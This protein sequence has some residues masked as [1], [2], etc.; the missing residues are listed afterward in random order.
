MKKVKGLNKKLQKIKREFSWC[1]AHGEYR[2]AL[3][4]AQAAHKLVPSISQPVSDMAV[5]SIYLNDWDGALRYAKSA[6]Q[7][8]P[9][10][11]AALDAASHALGVLKQYE[12]AALYGAKAIALRDAKV[13]FMSIE[14]MGPLLSRVPEGQKVIA[15]SLFGSKPKYCETAYLNVL[16]QP[17]IYPGWVCRFYVDRSVPSEVKKRLLGKGAQVIE[18]SA[19]MMGWPGTVWR[20]LALDDETVDRVIFRDADSIIG[21]RESKAVERWL[22]SD[23]DFH[24]MRDNGSHTELILAGMW[25]AVRGALPSMQSL[26]RQYLSSVNGESRFLDQYF[27]RAKVWPYVRN[28]CLHH[29]DIFAALGSEP[30]PTAFGEADWRVGDN[31]SAGFFESKV[32]DESKR[33]HDWKLLDNNGE[34][35]CEYSSPVC[36]GKIKV[37]LPRDL[38]LRI[39]AK[40]LV[41]VSSDAV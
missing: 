26:L 4:H 41:Y 16:S 22:D 39:Q 29:D 37:E 30:F 10:N 28:N 13:E 3:V 25:G 31:V 27:L 20:F 38:L 15:F 17:S 19:E 8:D 5:C 12:K 40:E 34:I 2:K 14:D 6:L 35:Y 33:Q 7:I 32:N 24:I 23:K 9:E 18:V 1:Y 36:N 11:I 21:S